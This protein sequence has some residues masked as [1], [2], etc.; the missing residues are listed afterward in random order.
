[1]NSPAHEQL[2]VHLLDVM[3]EVTGL[4]DASLTATTTFDEIGLQS[5]SIVAFTGRLAK[6]IPNIPQAFIYD[7]RNVEQVA[8]Y[9]AAR[10]AT[11]IQRFIKVDA[12]AP[13]PLADVPLPPP[14][15]V[16]S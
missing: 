16:R 1:M 4:D 14:A 11:E 13:P 15:D 2:I 3:R 6:F 7:C 12:P 5:L 8:A 9:L 10:Y